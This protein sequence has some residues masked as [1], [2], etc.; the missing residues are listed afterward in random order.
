MRLYFLTQELEKRM[1]SALMLINIKETAL[2][3]IENY[4]DEWAEIRRAKLKSE[5]KAIEVR[6]NRMKAQQDFIWR[7][8]DS[9]ARKGIAA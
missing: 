9:N 3:N 7:K 8:I 6:R 1:V 2:S 5:I 4:S